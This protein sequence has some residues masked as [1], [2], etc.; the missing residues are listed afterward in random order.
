MA[1]EEG[2]GL[3]DLTHDMVLDL[4]LRDWD[5]IGDDLR[6]SGWGEDAVRWR[7][8]LGRWGTAAAGV[9]VRAITFACISRERK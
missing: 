3:D 7:K 9:V 5:G 2:G 6:G 1:A 8:G 4:G